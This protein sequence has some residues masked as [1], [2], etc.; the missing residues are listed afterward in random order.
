MTDDVGG[1]VDLEAVRRMLDAAKD[2]PKQ[3]PP[4][5]RDDGLPDD[6]PVTALG[7]DR[8]TFCYLDPLR[9]IR[10]LREDKHGRLNLTGLF[11]SA[12]AQE[13]LY[14]T[15][16]R[17][18]KDGTVN[19]IR[20][21]KLAEAL[22]AACARR[23]VWSPLE[24]VR[25]PGG[26]L[27]AAGELIL[28]CG[29][30]ILVI[31]GRHEYVREPG[32]VGQVVYPAG[33]ALPRPLPGPVGGGFAADLLELLST[34]AWRRPE[35]D[36]VLLLGWIGCAIL[37]GALQ[38]RP[39]LWLTGG[40]GTG[41]ST[42]Q[43]HVLK[44]LFDGAA[45]MV[46]DTSQAGL[47]QALRCSTLPALVDELEA[48]ADYR[49]TQ[50]VIELAKLA[51][52]GALV[53]RGSSDHG[54][55]QFQ[56]RSAFLFSSIL[57]PPLAP[58]ER[59]RIA[60]LDL[61]PLAGRTR[62]RFDECRLNEIGRALRRRIIQAW[63]RLA[64]VI[65]RYNGALTLTEEGIEGSGV[66][67]DARGADVFA[68]LLA[69]AEVLL[70]DDIEELDGTQRAWPETVRASE[71]Q[72]IERVRDEDELLAYLLSSTIDPGRAGEARR[73]V[74]Q[75]LLG[76]LGRDKDLDQDK[77][78]RTLG[79]CGVWVGRYEFG[80][81]DAP[82]PVPC[83]GFAAKHQGLAR[84]LEG[85]HWTGPAGRASPWVQSIRRAARSLGGIEVSGTI[86]V[87]GLPTRCAII[88]ADRLLPVIMED[89]HLFQGP[90]TSLPP[91][92]KFI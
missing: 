25:G 79:T 72:A 84:L 62:P 1:V 34:W 51:A 92:T 75:W 28:H 31:D 17:H 80:G 6:C 50:G 12:S 54:E 8:G 2:P 23:G 91:V 27:G 41:K 9:Q 69:L 7:T 57:I 3:T 85:T 22:M 82:E 67:M 76:A 13:W 35:I 66:R 19:G 32:Q 5:V 53:L 55:V 38:W 86:K 26:W 42:L 18:G 65:A 71:A 83:V 24:R 90:V 78:V 68:A 87:G 36:P 39:M 15:F 29:D 61:D 30:Q 33:P 48:Q 45:V 60:V 89:P 47:R 40:A 70:V 77:A 74:A 49:K 64:E 20:W 56:V 10:T 44:P 43:D 21:E 14:A 63:P 88:P 59:S 16:P 37:G 11:C 81:A 46:G 4:K 58:A 73:T 52:S